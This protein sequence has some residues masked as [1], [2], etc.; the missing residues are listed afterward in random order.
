M[1]D[2]LEYWVIETIHSSWKMYKSRIKAG[3]FVAYE[4]DEMRSANRPDDIPLETFKM[5]LAYWND[6]S[7]Q[8]YVNFKHLRSLGNIAINF[9]INFC[10]RER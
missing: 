10:R 3:H 4:N 5:L 9:L 1:P 2:E 6:E 7:V 8:I